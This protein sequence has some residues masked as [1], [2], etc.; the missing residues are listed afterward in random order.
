MVAGN[1]EEHSPGMDDTSQLNRLNAIGVLTRREIEARI[2][3]PI[4]DALGREFGR[5]QVLEIAG[6]VVIQIARE[7]GAQLAAAAR[8]R[9]LAD[10]AGTLENWKKDDALQIEVLE[11]TDSKLSFNVTRCR[12][13]EMYSALGIPE[14]GALL[15]CNRD[16]ALIQ[17]FNPE[18]TL[19]R[20]QTIM[21]GAQFC[22][23]RYELKP[24]PKPGP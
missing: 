6:R 5:E 20:D 15:S 19:T 12:Y 23:F 10:F 1:M 16:W 21:E 2:V 11:Q 4:L 13:A 8:G 18:A 14:L 24:K 22:A 9:S 17:G 7:Q 3:A